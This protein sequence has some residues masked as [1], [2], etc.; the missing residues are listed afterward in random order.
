MTLFDYC[1]EMFALLAT[2]FAAGVMV[3]DTLAKFFLLY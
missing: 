1:I 2:V 3:E